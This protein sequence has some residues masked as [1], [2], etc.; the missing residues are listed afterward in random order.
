MFDKRILEEISN[1]NGYSIALLT[2]F[3]FEINYFERAI[4]NSLFD[5][6]IRNVELFVDADRLEKALSETLNNNLNRK[7][8]ANPIRINSAFH[9]KVILLLGEEKAKLIV[10]SANIKTSGYML[11]NEIYNVFEYNKDNQENL[12]LINDGINFFEKLNSMSYYQDE[13]IFN[14]INDFIY[15]HRKSD[16]NDIKLI[17]NMDKS[18]LNHLK[19]IITD[20]VLSIDIAVPYYDN[21]L[22]GYKDITETFNCSN[23]NLYLQNG[24]STFPVD[25]N[26]NYNL[27]NEN[28][29]F[30]Y[31]KLKSN[32]KKNFYHGKVFRIN[33][34]DKSYILYGS[35]NCTVS[36]LSKTYHDGGNIECNILESGLKSDFDYF[37]DNFEIESFDELKCNI[38]DYKSKEKKNFSFKYGIKNDEIKLYLSY[39]DKTTNAAIKI[40][41]KSLKFEY[42]DKDLIINIDKDLSDEIN[43]VLDLTIT[44]NENKEIIRCWYFD[45]DTV[46]NY[47]NVGKTSSFDD[48]NVDEDME[49]YREHMEL[50]V[51]TLALTKDEY[52]EQM[53]LQKLFNKKSNLESQE[54]L[55]E[56]EL[57]DNFIIDKDI[58]DEYVRKNK[59]FT[60]AYIKSKLFADRF[61]KGLKFKSGNLSINHSD[62]DNRNPEKSKVKRLATPAEKRFER[63]I[64]SRVK[65]ILR[66][67]YVELVDYEHYKNSIGVILDVINEYKHKEQVEDIFEDKY[68][69]EVSLNMINKLLDKESNEHNIEEKETT[70]ILVFISIIEN[71]M[72]NSSKETTNYKYELVNKEIVKRLDQLFNIR[73]NYE[74]LLKFAVDNISGAIK[75]IDFN[76]YKNYIESL[77]GYKTKIQL[78]DIIRKKFD[79]SAEIKTDAGDV[80][81]KF[82]TV[83]IVKFFKL[84]PLAIK[85]IRNYYKNQN[86]VLNSINIEIINVKNDYPTTA[87]PIQKIVYEIDQNGLYIK[88]MKYRDGRKM[89]SKKERI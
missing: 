70:I 81:I 27:I 88:K 8:I 14:M 77:F 21:E 59:D 43:N 11:N 40:G 17:Q 30:T 85:E 83:D 6:N 38:M 67:E 41:E 73:E 22:L 72:I 15:R 66:D 2:T 26:R 42:I 49:K 35:S 25:Y 46:N 5:K 16:N 76:F 24:L 28:N 55:D 84:D 45:I 75:E 31:L 65:G 3:N 71:H 37:F 62:A 12:N 9:P 19:E 56:D 29:I 36:A 80:S 58:P 20:K 89:D 39:K 33:T 47:R 4:L 87:N 32:G 69:M 10:S 54:D 7:Y 23:V 78:L 64:K 74:E 53:K 1:S 57:D 82:K 50:I 68:V 51:R 48:I 63:F 44:F 18:V 34:I 60:N 13:R 86:I 61:F 79:S 52:S